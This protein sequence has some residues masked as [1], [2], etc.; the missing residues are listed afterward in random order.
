MR[1]LS[2]CALAAVLAATLIRAAPAAPQPA[3]AKPLDDP[4]AYAV[5]AALLPNQWTVRHAKASILVF[6]QET[7]SYPRCMPSGPLL[8]TEW[9]PVVDSYRVENER[10]R[11]LQPGLPL[12]IP[13]MVVP[14]AD[15]T[16]AL[17]EVPNDQQFGWTG[18]YAR[19]PNSRGYMVAS[20]PGFDAEQRRAMVYMGH[21]CGGLCG[22][23]T[24][25]FL[26]KADGAWR[27]VRLPGITMCAWAS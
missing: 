11:L 24:Y 1:Q 10:A 15:I 13:Y 26:Q 9:K 18:F 6:Q 25:H 20:V 3:G 16:A 19:Y 17:R 4:E 2:G 21:S 23:G 27:E 5:Y 22:G 12:G 8:D 14:R 7:G